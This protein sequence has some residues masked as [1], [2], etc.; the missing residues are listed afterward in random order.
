MTQVFTYSEYVTDYVTKFLQDH[1]DTPQVLKD[2]LNGF[3][4]VETN[5]DDD[6]EDYL[7][8]AAYVPSLGVIRSVGTNIGSGSLTAI[9]W[10]GIEFQST[11]E[12]DWIVG[13]PTRITMEERGIVDLKGNVYI[14]ASAAGVYRTAQIYVNGVT[15]LAA[16]TI[17]PLSDGLS[18]PRVSVSVTYSAE[19]GDYFEL[20]TN[21]D[22]GG[23]LAVTGRFSCS[24]LGL[25][26]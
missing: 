25:S 14:A 23:A 4:S 10:E 7:S 2:Y 16:M 6:I 21:Q 13:A 8:A 20:F 3:S 18:P 5:R 9:P 26:G 24:Y 12:F 19:A 17:P 1:P 11:S 22:S 15:E